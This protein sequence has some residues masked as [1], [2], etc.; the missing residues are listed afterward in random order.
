MRKYI[1]ALGSV[2]VLV[3]LLM[4]SARAEPVKI[5]LAWVTPVATWG[6]ILLEKKDLAKHLGQSYVLE[7]I[8]FQGTPLMIT[9]MANGEL[10]IGNLA[11]STFALAVQNA[12]MDDLRVIADEFQD[13]AEGYYSN[14][15]LVLKDGGIDKVGDLKGKVLATNSAGS[16]IDIAMRA[17]LRRHGL[18]DKRDYSVVEAQFPAMRAMLEE[19]KVAMMQGVLPFSL[20]PELKKISRALFTSKDA[21]G[22]SQFVFWTARKAFLDKNRA[23][24]NDFMEDTLRIERWFLDPANHDEVM[25]I[26]ARVTK[27]PPERFAYAFTKADYYR[28]PNMLPDLTALQ[29][30]I[31]TTRELGFV[32]IDIDVPKFADLS[33]AQEA[34]KRLK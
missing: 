7:P 34:A 12:K 28:D 13:G 16:A 24:M 33:F 23:A 27:Q 21:I 26:A 32:K 1:T 29:S 19:K 8:R 14:E 18:E 17:M 4:G 3:A 5:R 30:N 31:N 15:F 22:R 25:Q 11:Y 9:A 10:E 2:G 6:S 20:D